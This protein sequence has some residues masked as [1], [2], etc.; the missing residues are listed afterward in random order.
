MTKKGKSKRTGQSSPRR[1]VS[2]PAASM[3]HGAPRAGSRESATHP[4]DALF[5]D[6]PEMIYEAVFPSP[7]GR[8]F[9]PGMPPPPFLGEPSDGPHSMVKRRIIEFWSTDWL[10]ND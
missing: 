6:T 7:Y 3:R 1:E 8:P 2:F 9:R 4:Y 10:G 5:S